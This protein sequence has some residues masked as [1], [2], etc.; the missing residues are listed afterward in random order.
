MIGGQ[1]PNP[2]E[3]HSTLTSAIRRI[4]PCLYIY[5]YSLGIEYDFKTS[6]PSSTDSR[7]LEMAIVGQ[8]FNCCIKKRL[9]LVDICSY[10]KKYWSVLHVISCGEM[11]FAAVRLDQ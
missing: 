2:N 5:I 7:I 3:C 9:I 4:Y 8:P 6:P 11:R 1:L 10:F